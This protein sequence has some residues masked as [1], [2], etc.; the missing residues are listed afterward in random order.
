MEVRMNSQ[1]QD[2]LNE[3]LAAYRQF[4]A[5]KAIATCRLVHYAGAGAPNAKDVSLEK[6]EGE[7]IGCMSEGLIIGWNL[8]D[9]RLFLAAQEPDCP[10]PPWPNVIAEGPLVDVDVILKAAGHNRGA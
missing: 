4:V 7:I 2:K 8:V 10:A 1:F 9:S 6:I 5:G 3:A